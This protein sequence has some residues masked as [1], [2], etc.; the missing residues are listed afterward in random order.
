MEVLQ[1]I[2]LSIG[3]VTGSFSFLL[4]VS[5]KFRNLILKS[6]KQKTAEKERIDEQKETDKCL[7]RDAILTNYK[8]SKDVKKIDRDGYE[9]IEHLYNQYKKLGGNSFVDKLWREIQTWEIIW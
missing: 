8:A 2:S 7:L 1:I 6:K 4:L 5:E 3:I 9:N